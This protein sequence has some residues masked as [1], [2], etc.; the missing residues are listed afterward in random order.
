[1]KL[2]FHPV[3]TTC[4][5]IMLF[6]AEH[7][8]ALDYQFI[9]LFTGAHRQPD[10]AAINPCCQVPMLEDGDFRLG[11]SSAILKYLADLQGSPA[12]PGDLRKRARVNEMMDWLNT[13]LYRDL[14]YGLIYPQVLPH[15]K[16][17]D[18]AVQTALLAGAR[19]RARRSLSVLDQHLIG[20]GRPYLCGDEMTLA[21]YLGAPMITVGEVIRLDYS[22]YANVSAW[23]DRVKARPAWAKVNEGFYA[24]FVAP[25]KD[26]PFEG[27]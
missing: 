17:A 12:Y 8:L 18:A 24:H 10:Y 15:Y 7:G 26:A 11:E 20:D 1:M 3:S 6:A 27:L 2:Y 25:F 14:G 9:D 13:G 22:P 19:E 4:R 21:D 16:N 5:P 23:L